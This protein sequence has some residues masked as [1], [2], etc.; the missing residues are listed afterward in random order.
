LRAHVSGA[1]LEDISRDDSINDIHALFVEAPALDTSSLEYYII[2]LE[3]VKQMGEG[4]HSR[5]PDGR[6]NL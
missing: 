2:Y 5:R 6:G 1:G 4:K 3:V